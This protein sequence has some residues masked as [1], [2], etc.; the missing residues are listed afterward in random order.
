MTFPN[1][2]LKTHQTI[3]HPISADN[4]EL[5]SGVTSERL[6][7]NGSSATTKEEAKRTSRVNKSNLT[8]GSFTSIK[9]DDTT[10]MG[11]MPCKGQPEN[12]RTRKKAIKI[13][14]TGKK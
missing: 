6:S 12:N 4:I 7:K 11:R 8:P 9:F 3:S 13:G 14:H 1:V 10:Q 5:R 2:H